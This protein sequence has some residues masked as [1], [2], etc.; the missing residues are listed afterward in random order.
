[1]L[2]CC[3]CSYCVFVRMPNVTTVLTCHAHTRLP[4]SFDKPLVYVCFGDGS[5]SR[6]QHYT[7]HRSLYQLRSLK[8]IYFLTCPYIPYL[9]AYPNSVLS[10][11][12]DSV[13]TLALN[14]SWQFSAEPTTSLS[15]YKQQTEFTPCFSYTHRISRSQ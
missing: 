3:G 2:A 5:R 13:L 8:C 6:W 11:L 7:K 14:L 12:F 10:S 4:Q 15:G 1:M 9:L